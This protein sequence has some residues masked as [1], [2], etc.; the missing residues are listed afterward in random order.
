MGNRSIVESSEVKSNIIEKAIQKRLK[1]KGCELE[2]MYNRYQF[3]K[4]HKEEKEFDYCIMRVQVQIMELC[5]L[6][7]CDG[8]IYGFI[9]SSD[10]YPFIMM[11]CNNPSYQKSIRNIKEYYNPTDDDDDSP[12]LSKR[13]EIY[14]KLIQDDH[15]EVNWIYKAYF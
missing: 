11:S 12:I 4:H 5:K 3:A 8:S 2:L 14:F 15:W 7:K 1:L 6:G 9:I 13:N 10:H